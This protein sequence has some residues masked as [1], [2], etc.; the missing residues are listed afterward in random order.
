LSFFTPSRRCCLNSP[1]SKLIYGIC[2]RYKIIFYYITIFISSNVYILK[3]RK[4]IWTWLN[5]INNIW[6]STLKFNL[7]LTS[8]NSKKFVGWHLSRMIQ[9]LNVHT[10]ER[11]S[12]IF[13]FCNL[14][15]IKYCE[16]LKKKF[17]ISNLNNIYINELNTILK[18]CLDQSLVHILEKKN[19]L[20][21]WFNC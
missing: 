4:K 3:N 20:S 19:I 5:C 14:N 6:L 18:I 16:I 15:C 7:I 1:S 12:H 2:I 10:S 11:S 8:H 21:N 9:M 17:R 13:S